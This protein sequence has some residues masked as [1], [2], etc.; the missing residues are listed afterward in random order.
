LLRGTGFGR[1]TIRRLDEPEKLNAIPEDRDAPLRKW[2][3]MDGASF[4]RPSLTHRLNRKYSKI[5]VHPLRAG[6][7]VRDDHAKF[8]RCGHLS[9]RARPKRALRQNPN[10]Q[11]EGVDRPNANALIESRGIGWPAVSSG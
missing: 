1:L 7:N 11:M 9:R 8:L 2:T 6:F 5:L 3:L 10:Q 4:A